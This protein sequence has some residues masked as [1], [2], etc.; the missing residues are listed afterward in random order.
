[1]V[2]IVQVVSPLSEQLPE[3]EALLTKLIL[4]MINFC[5]KCCDLVCALFFELS[6]G[7]R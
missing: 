2:L 6:V 5:L 7:G 4:T 1:M 3:N